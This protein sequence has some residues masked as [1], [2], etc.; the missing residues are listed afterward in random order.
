MLLTVK[1]NAF[2]NKVIK[3][4]SSLNCYIIKY[5]GGGIYTKS[6]VPD[7]LICYDGFFL[8]IELKT[9]TGV[10]AE[11]QTY[12]IKKIRQSDGIAIILR[13]KTFKLF[14]KYLNDGVLY[15]NQREFN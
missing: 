15:D 14:L 11:L 8:G 13:P 9:D 7:L 5:W 12:N 3:E 2:K 1:E 4:L 10:V 6:G